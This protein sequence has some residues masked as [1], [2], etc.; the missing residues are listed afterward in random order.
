MSCRYGSTQSYAIGVGTGPNL[1]TSGRA[2]RLLTPV[3][4]RFDSERD[5]ASLFPGGLTVAETKV[6]TDL[7]LELVDALCMHPSARKDSVLEEIR[8]RLPEVEESKDEAQNNTIRFDLR[9]A[10]SFP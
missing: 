8:S 1:Q 4:R 6:N 9:L 7:G 2:D 3:I 5:L 10:A